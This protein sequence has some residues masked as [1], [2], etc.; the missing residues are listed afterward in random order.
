MGVSVFSQNRKMT[1]AK[2]LKLVEEE[3]RR[4]REQEQETDLTETKVIFPDGDTAM[5]ETISFHKLIAL[6]I[7]REHSRKVVGFVL[8]KLKE[9]LTR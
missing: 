3:R 6:N 1:L 4:K 5:T 2:H 9:F 8:K 7:S